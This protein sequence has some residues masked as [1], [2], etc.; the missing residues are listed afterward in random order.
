[1]ETKT[2]ET[3]K[4]IEEVKRYE[5]LVAQI[6][7]L[8]A[9]KSVL[10]KEFKEN[11]SEF[12]RII[13]DNVLLEIID[14]ET[15]TPDRKKMKLILGDKYDALCKLAHSKKLTISKVEL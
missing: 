6:K 14:V 7:E 11:W 5:T 1:M 15:R 10:A 3:T 12:K 13:A 8:T 9:E 2:L 4:E